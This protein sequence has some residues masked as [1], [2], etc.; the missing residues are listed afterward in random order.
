MT[1]GFAVSHWM[2][3]VGIG[4]L[5]YGKKG[6]V[7]YQGLSLPKCLRQEPLCIKVMVPPGIEGNCSMPRQMENI[8][9]TIRYH[10]S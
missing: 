6:D 10:T 7:L 8:R 5:K 1:S 9:S 4:T 2:S 3:A